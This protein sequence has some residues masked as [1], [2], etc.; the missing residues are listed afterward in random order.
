MVMRHD[1]VDQSEI[2]KFI[3]EL[4]EKLVAFR[5]ARKKGATLKVWFFLKQ[6]FK[7]SQDEKDEPWMADFNVEDFM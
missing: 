2:V 3:A 1:K 5:Q 6:N 7:F 4:L